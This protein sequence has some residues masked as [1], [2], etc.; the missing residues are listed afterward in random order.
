MNDLLMQILPYALTL[1]LGIL[2]KRYAGN[3]KKVKET[4][5]D[6]IILLDDSEKALKDD[7]LTKEEIMQIVKDAKEI[8]R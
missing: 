1:L 7:K 8:V 6:V 4:I 3:L 5:T 2:T